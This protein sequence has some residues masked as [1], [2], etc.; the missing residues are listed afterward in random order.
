MGSYE[1]IRC[2]EGGQGRPAPEKAGGSNATI[3][4]LVS[5]EEESGAG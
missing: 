5:T 1:H 3:V 2:R 4:A